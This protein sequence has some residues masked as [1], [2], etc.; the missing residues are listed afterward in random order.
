[1]P[2]SMFSKSPITTKKRPHEYEFIQQINTDENFNTIKKVRFENDFA[3]LVFDCKSKLIAKVVN[4]VSQNILKL[5]NYFSNPK[6]IFMYRNYKDVVNSNLNHFG[7]DNGIN[8]LRPI[9]N[10]E[11]NNWRSEYV[12]KGD[13]P[14]P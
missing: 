1:M 12:S 3:K 10:N 4:N 2:A 7:I 14:R 6:A 5:L 8:D 13:Q 11:N 9:H